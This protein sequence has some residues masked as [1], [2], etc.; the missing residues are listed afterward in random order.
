MGGVKHQYLEQ[1]SASPV[2]WYSPEERL[3]IQKQEAEK[4]RARNEN[5]AA[6][7]SCDWDPVP[8]SSAV[9]SWRN[10]HPG[11]SSSDRWVIRHIRQCVRPLGAQK[12]NGRWVVNEN[13]L[14]L[15]RWELW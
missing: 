11:V 8:I 1:R 6:M 10:A 9:A 15:I 14:S 13:A 3:Q 7:R 12:V 2:R 4:E 5:A